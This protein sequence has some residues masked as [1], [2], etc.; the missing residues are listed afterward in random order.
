[1]ERIETYN[2]V[3]KTFAFNLN[4]FI[5]FC[6]LVLSYLINQEILVIFFICHLSLLMI[7]EKDM[8]NVFILLMSFIPFYQII[9]INKGNFKIYVVV[10]F[11]FLIR[12]LVNL[13]FKSKEKNENLKFQQCLCFV[14]AFM[15]YYLVSMLLT[16]GLDL[17]YLFGFIYI[18]SMFLGLMQ[19]KQIDSIKVY[20]YYLFM[21]FMSALL[22]SCANFI[23]ALDTILRKA[24]V[25]GIDRFS[26]VSWDTNYFALQCCCNVGMLL[27]L[28]EQRKTKKIIYICCFLV[29][30]ILG[31]TTVSKM[32][33]VGLAVMFVLWLFASKT[34]IPLK[35]GAII[36]L[37]VG[38]IIGYY[39]LPETNSIRVLI[40]RFLNVF[41]E[42]QG[43]NQITTGRWNIW[44]TY[45]NDW[46]QSWFTIFFGKG[47]SYPV[48]IE[49][50]GCHGF[51]V[52]T[53]YQFGL[54][55]SLLFLIAFL[56][57][58][59]YGK[60]KVQNKKITTPKQ[61]KMVKIERRRKRINYLALISVLVSYAALSI[62]N[63]VDSIFL[64]I[65]SC[66]IFN[67]DKETIS[68][69]I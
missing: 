65:V 32:Y 14:L 31:I 9:A 8:T 48:L 52:E 62:F 37:I 17:G 56:F 60:E 36:L 27:S 21:F 38:I 45:M 35:I 59:F 47:V 54:L 64:M 4:I 19:I 33:I 13:I 1:M 51:Y 6:E 15:L 16:C 18:F 25:G 22:G 44:S 53:I 23:P 39:A 7:M 29:V 50:F 69:E 26:G 12:S 49:G 40:Q 5:L 24:T 43:L 42:S 57:S 2:K 30:L 46:I 58:I 55:G 10:L 63:Q 61:Y 41:T 11:V 68:N 66:L 34:K 28:I 3:N 20:H 67:V